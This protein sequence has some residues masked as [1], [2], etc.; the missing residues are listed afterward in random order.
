MQQP[1]THLIFYELK[2]ENVAVVTVMP[3]LEQ[4]DK[5]FCLHSKLKVTRHT[6]SLSLFLFFFSLLEKT[7]NGITTISGTISKQPN[8]LKIHFIL[9]LPAPEFADCIC[10]KIVSISDPSW[11]GNTKNISLCS[12]QPEEQVYFQQLLP[13]SHQK[14]KTDIIIMIFLSDLLQNEFY[15]LVSAKQYRKGSC[16]IKRTADH[17]LS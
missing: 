2:G 14:W 7:L 13:P 5:I 15:E 6:D 3:R 10:R 16:L 17:S 9:S 1:T 11:L 12:K 4:S 8:Y